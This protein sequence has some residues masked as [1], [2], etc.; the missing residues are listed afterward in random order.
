MGKFL[1][2]VKRRSQDFKAFPIHS[3]GLCLLQALCAD[4]TD[5]GRIP[6]HKPPPLT[7]RAA[8]TSLS[9]LTVNFLQPSHEF[10]FNVGID[11]LF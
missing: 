6:A 5:L 8:V 3:R 2:E 1:N 10:T 4:P 11:L 9:M 7:T